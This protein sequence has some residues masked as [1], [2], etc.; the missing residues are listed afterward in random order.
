MAV[1]I[2]KDYVLKYPVEILARGT[3]VQFPEPM[4]QK[5][6]AVLIGNGIE[7]GDFVSEQLSMADITENTLILTME[8]KQRATLVE[9]F[10]DVI[11]EHIQSLPHFVGEELD[12]TNPYGGSIQT[13]GIC[14][15]S[16]KKSIKKLVELLNMEEVLWSE[17]EESGE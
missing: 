4:N 13:Y 5:A 9:M 15:E 2:L 7:V 12:I 11:S 16:L 10:P 14:F 3:V 6:E 1:G 8:E 17:K